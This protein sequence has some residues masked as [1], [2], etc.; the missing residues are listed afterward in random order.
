MDY[1]YP[2]T[3]A[4]H[5]TAAIVQPA[6]AKITCA[7]VGNKCSL[8]SMPG[9]LKSW[10]TKYREATSRLRVLPAF[11]IVGAQRSGTS[12][13]YQYL[14][15]H[16]CIGGAYRKEVSYFDRHYHRGLNW[17]RSHFPTVLQK[18]I[19]LARGGAFLPGEAS[20][21]YLLN[22]A[23][24]GR[25]AAALPGPKLIAILR[26][27]IDRAYSGY[28]REVRKGR[29]TRTFADAA[30]AELP[31]PLNGWK[32]DRSGDSLDTFYHRSYL[33]RG[34]YAEQVQ[35]WMTL[36]PPDRFLLLSSEEFFKD[37]LGVLNR[38]CN[39]LGLPPW[40]DQSFRAS[41][42]PNVSK[43]LRRKYSY[44]YPPLEPA[45]RSELA[46]FFRPHNEQLYAIA[47]KDFGWQKE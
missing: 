10:E 41:V 20:P 16:P 11:L 38:T 29:E 23:V 44:Q 18:R 12:T 30:R 26:D 9:L 31:N 13:L 5:V 34:L 32:D 25:V 21:N 35:H 45:L 15:R 37:A 24:P 1:K 36:F 7:C 14:V 17:Y 40:R 39:F 2:A 4:R 6:T 28:Q 22:A 33:A 43:W 8:A 3:A 42:L 46:R 27:P 19:A 47:G